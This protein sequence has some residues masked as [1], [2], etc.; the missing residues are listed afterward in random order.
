MFGRDQK[1]AYDPSSE[2][3]YTQF[4][5]ATFRYIPIETHPFL[6]CQMADETP[7]ELL[8]HAKAG[9]QEAISSLVDFLTPY[10]AK[11]C[12]YLVAGYGLDPAL[13][14]DL[15]QSTLGSVIA[16]FKEG[17][18]PDLAN[19]Q[20]LRALVW[21]IIRDKFVDKLRKK[22]RSGATIHD[23]SVLDQLESDALAPDVS[24]AIQDVWDRFMEPFEPRDRAI[25][26]LLLA[27]C[28]LAQIKDL[29]SPHFKG[30]TRYRVDRVQARLN[31]RLENE[32]AKHK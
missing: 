27:D 20:T 19:R 26:E 30:V 3:V 8:P 11:A 9:R 13:A 4:A 15:R 25:A 14:D 12:S 22:I 29:L 17:R 21:K 18:W 6:E 7:T 10:V 1:I 28:T 16:G 5:A 32:A 31:R 24:V 23:Q 2:G